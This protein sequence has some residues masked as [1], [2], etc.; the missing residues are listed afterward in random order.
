MNPNLSD[1]QFSEY[2]ERP[3]P[4]GPGQQGVLFR[5]EAPARGTPDQRRGI[6]VDRWGEERDE[7]IMK[8]R[9]TG[10]V[11]RELYHGTSSRFKPDS[12]VQPGKPANFEGYNSGY[13]KTQ[14]VNHEHVFA[15]P[16]LHDAYRYAMVSQDMQ[17]KN[18]G[19]ERRPHVYRVQPTGPVQLDP[20]DRENVY[21][22]NPPEAFQSKHPFRVLNPIQL[23][24]ARDEYQY[25]ME[26]ELGERPGNYQFAP[27]PR[28]EDYY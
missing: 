8:G 2:D 28:M 20:E 27:K 25:Y 10:F 17:S 12:K 21:E 26:D 14:D 3:D 16:N 4:K 13:G 18:R 11:P 19:V 23:S 9:A 5:K 22:G 15:T 1:D 6:H 24:Q 7:R